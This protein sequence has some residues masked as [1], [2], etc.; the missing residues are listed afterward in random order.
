[1][2]F[3]NQSEIS[4]R[5]VLSVYDPFKGGASSI[6]FFAVGTVSFLRRG[7]PNKNPIEAPKKA[8]PA[9]TAVS[10]IMALTG[11]HVPAVSVSSNIKIVN[12]KRVK[13]ERRNKILSS[14]SVF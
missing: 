12:T 8:Q 2:I 6:P 7:M 5:F 13:T 10:V 3:V 11:E 14:S 1:M 9:A 4:S